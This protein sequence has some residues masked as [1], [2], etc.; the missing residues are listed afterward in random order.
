MS[1][2]LCRMR[3]FS[4]WSQAFQT[5]MSSTMSLVSSL[6]LQQYPAK[7]AVFFAMGINLSRLLTFL[8]SVFNIVKA[9]PLLARVGKIDKGLEAEMGASVGVKSTDEELGTG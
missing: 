9:V 5:S 4:L 3:T 1:E 8:Q 6:E 2:M 7:G